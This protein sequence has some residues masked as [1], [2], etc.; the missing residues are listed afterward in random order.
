MTSAPDAPDREH[1]L[2]TMTALLMMAFLI[3]IAYAVCC[4]GVATGAV[5]LALFAAVVAFVVVARPDLVPTAPKE[6]FL[7]QA[8]PSTIE[9]EFDRYPGPPPPMRDGAYRGAIDYEDPNDAAYRFAGAPAYCR[10]RRDDGACLRTEADDDIV[11]G[12][13]RLVNN[14]LGRNDPTR[15]QVGLL[16]RRRDLERNF[17]EEL[18]EEE[19]RVWWGR[20]EY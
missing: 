12:D 18:E 9:D 20:S 13:E 4:D 10:S 15:P 3:A 16:N 5:M 7:S 1:S 11:G 14:A 2:R 6:D 8:Y 19:G 17:V